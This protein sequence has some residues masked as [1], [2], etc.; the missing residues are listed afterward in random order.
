M[1]NVRRHALSNIEALNAPQCCAK[2]MQCHLV[3]LGDKV[4]CRDHGGLHGSN[5]PDVVGISEPSFLPSI[6]SKAQIL[7]NTDGYE[8]NCM[9]QVYS[10]RPR[11]FQMF[12]VYCKVL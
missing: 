3:L 7:P 2:C 8:T 1:F 10:C 4:M 9:L 11:Y 6:P 12:V 5:A